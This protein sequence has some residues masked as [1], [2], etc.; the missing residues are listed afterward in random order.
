[1]VAELR[2]HTDV[3]LPGEGGALVNKWDTLTPVLIQSIGETVYMVA[4]SLL[5]SGVAGLVI[6]ALLYAT[7]PGNLF[8]NRA[9]FAVANLVI[10]LIRPIPFIIFLTAV[11]PVTRAVTG[12]TLGTDAAIVP[13]TIMATVVIARVVEQNLVPSTRNR[14]GARAVGA[15]RI[16]VLFGVVIPEALAPLILGY[17][18]MFIAVVD[19][20]AMAGTSAAADSATSRSSTAIQQFISRRRG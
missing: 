19:M 4:V 1:M 2:A 17:T 14:R 20:S 3:V 7:R 13:I 12:T 11:A 15:R 6:G 18:F 9:V 10:N 8:A 5:I 16:G